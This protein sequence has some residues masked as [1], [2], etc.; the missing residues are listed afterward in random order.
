MLLDHETSGR[1]RLPAYIYEPAKP[2]LIQPRHDT[3]TREGTLVP[4]R[5]VR[6]ILHRR[7]FGPGLV[8]VRPDET[9][10]GAARHMAENCCGSV[11]VMEGGRLLGLLTERDLLVRVVAAG[12][13]PART[14][15]REVMTADPETIGAEEP[16]DQAVR[17][18]DEGGLR[19]LVVVDRGRVL[20]VLSDRDI[21]ALARGR[22]AEEIDGR[23]RQAERTW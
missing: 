14:P 16:V 10:L 7:R 3:R 8:G 9:A 11:P 2:A 4:E 1:R 17:R 18:M 19:H 12:L 22:M 23:H 15:V 13:E 5:H 6:S 20:G 21:P